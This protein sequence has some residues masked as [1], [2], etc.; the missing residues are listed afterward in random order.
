MKYFTLGTMSQENLTLLHANTCGAD[1]PVHLHSLI[2]AYVIRSLASMV[3]KY[4][5]ATIS[6]F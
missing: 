4:A 2:S 3:A 1:Q 6:L 5:T